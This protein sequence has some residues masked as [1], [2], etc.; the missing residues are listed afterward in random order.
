[1]T[2]T[3]TAPWADRFEAARK[4][5]DATPTP[6]GFRAV[7]ADIAATKIAHADGRV[8]FGDARI[9]VEYAAPEP[10]TGAP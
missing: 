2:I 8:E 4:A 9:G 1:M 10:P 3:F 6:T 5:L 7:S